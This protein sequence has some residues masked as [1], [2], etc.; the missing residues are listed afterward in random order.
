VLPTLGKV[1]AVITDPPYG[2]SL[3]NH[4]TTGMFRATRD[5]TIANDKSLD[6][7]LAVADW[8]GDTPL[9]MFCSPDKPIP[10]KWRSRLVWHKHGLGMGGDPGKCW[11]RDWELILVRGN[12]ELQGG[13][14]SAILS[15]E[16]RPSEFQHPTQKP[17]S[18]M[19][20]LLKKLGCALTLDPFVGS[21]TTGVAAVNL[22]REF[23][24]I[25][26]DEGYFK[27]SQDRIEQAKP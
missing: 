12:A 9:I 26:L 20:Y 18:L 1:D 4:D 6:V 5:W 14:D 13:R 10:G 23:I 19:S 21:G 3:K 8:C 15:Y 22:N 24:G 17:V 7:A 11:R 27:I 16:I 2:I 25:E